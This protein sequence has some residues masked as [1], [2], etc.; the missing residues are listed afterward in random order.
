MGSKSGHWPD[1]EDSNPRE[2]LEFQPATIPPD[3]PA[4][5]QRLRIQHA[6]AGGRHV[7]AVATDG[8]LWSAGDGLSGQLG[9]GVRQFGLCTPDGVVDMEANETEEEFAVKWEEMEVEALQDRECMAVFA[10]EQ[11]TFIL[12]RDP[13]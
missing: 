4:N 12:T 5:T 6:A 3:K 7:V 13:E 9:I 8:S 11:Q 2:A 1:I 10:N